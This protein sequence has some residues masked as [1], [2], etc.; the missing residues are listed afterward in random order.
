MGMLGPVLELSGL[1]ICGHGGPASPRSR[2]LA[3]LPCWNVRGKEKT[4]DAGA[5]WGLTLVV[6]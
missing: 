1:G 6:L 5:G 2:V 3:Q 4:H